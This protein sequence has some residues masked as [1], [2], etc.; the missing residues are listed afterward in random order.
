[1]KFRMVDQIV[2]WEKDRGIRGVKAVSFEE[3]T[4]K[5]PLGDPERLPESLVLESACQLASWLMVLSSDFIQMGQMIGIEQAEF[6]DALRPGER[7]DLTV[8][9]RGMDDESIL[10]DGV[11]HARTRQI[12]RIDG[13]RMS[14]LPLAGY[15]DAN[16]LR[17]LCSEIYRPGPGELA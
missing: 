15:Q 6:T 13:L 7:L 2:A 5:T 16:D 9:V 4:L 17:V 8:R 14:R 10:L 12:V 3:Y 1:M 11:G